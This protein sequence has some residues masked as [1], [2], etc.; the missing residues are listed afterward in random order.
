MV[1]PRDHLPLTTGVRGVVTEVCFFRLVDR[2][3]FDLERSLRADGL[4][5]V[6]HWSHVWSD[7]PFLKLNSG[8]GILSLHM[9]VERRPRRMDGFGFADGPKDVFSEYEHVLV[10]EGAALD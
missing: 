6:V 10:G 9:L 7:E 5:D 2:T 8:T 3:N 4:M 1:R